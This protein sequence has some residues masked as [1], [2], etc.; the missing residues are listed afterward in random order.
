MQDYLA[1]RAWLP[2]WL[3]RQAARRRWLV[4]GAWCVAVLLAATQLPRLRI[5]TNTGSILDKAAPAWQ[6]YQDA[7]RLF[8]GDEVVVIALASDEPFA[9]TLVRRAGVLSNS[10]AELP[11][12][13]RVDSVTT[14]P[15][16]RQDRTGAVVLEPLLRGGR[17]PDGVGPAALVQLYRGDRLASRSLVSADGHVLAVNVLLEQ[18]PDA[19]YRAIFDGITAA[20]GPEAK[21]SGVPV[22]RY[23]ANEETRRQLVLFGPITLLVIAAGALLLFRSVLG[24]VVALLPGGIATTIVM[25]VMALV[26]MP[27]T[28]STV[29]LPPILLAVG[30][31]YAVHIFAGMRR[32]GVPRAAREVAP[33]VALSALTTVLGL[34][35][36]AMVEIEAIRQLGV[37]GSL[38]TLI[39]GAAAL[40]VVPAIA[41]AGSGA[42]QMPVAWTPRT[43][44]QPVVLAIGCGA[45]FVGAIGL[46]SL[47]VET[48]VIR[49]FPETHPARV[50]YEWVRERLSGISPVNL[51]VTS[52]ERDVAAPDVIRSL[53]EMARQFEARPEVGRVIS[54]ADPID[55]LH[56]ALMGSGASILGSG[57]LVEQ[58]LLLLESSEQLRDYISADRRHANIVFRVDDNTS[59]TLVKIGEEA[60]TW[61]RNHGPSDTVPAATGVMY[62]FGR[63]EDAIAE[64]QLRAL[65]VAGA[66]IGLVLLL[67]TRNLW[68][69]SAALVANVLPLVVIFGIM[70]L[71]GV[72]VDAG[73]V[74]V[75]NLA[76]GIG[77]D[78]SIHVVSA[79]QRRLALGSGASADAVQDAVAEV[80]LPVLLTT[81][82]LCAGFAVLALSQLAFTRELGL[83]TVGV[84]VMCLLADLWLLPGLLRLRSPRG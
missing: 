61:W 63:A 72:P 37:M 80:G 48:D 38:G 76:L 44:P 51:V 16:I 11:G 79:F 82:I 5:E 35:G 14:V 47:R 60:E 25:G 39:A 9:E 81:V 84:L 43:V 26:G 6:E 71:L 41:G 56:E 8:G 27:V 66:T 70:G 64:G 4:L 30:C 68:I 31:A 49:W 23:L 54:I 53:R 73:T 20:T 7:Q 55:D 10:L 17:I 2:E 62:E 33:S 67:I 1:T 42:R 58:Y 40:T 3:V 24:A 69:A 78:D 22:F 77:V 36:V 29:I 19:H 57:E 74:L 13:R 50:Q 18:N 15:L 65:S 75:G 34:L 45:V 32:W 59:R 12:V 46:P 21:V 83:L 52:S 28:I